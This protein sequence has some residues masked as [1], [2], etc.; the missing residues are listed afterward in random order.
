MLTSEDG[1]GVVVTGVTES[2]SAAR[3]KTECLGLL[4]S[5]VKGDG[6]GP[7][8]AVSKAHVLADAV[9]SDNSR[10]CVSPLHCALR[11]QSACPPLVVGLAKETL[12]GREASVHDELEIA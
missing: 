2:D 12:E 11:S 8:T 1:E 10:S 7:Q 4:R 3:V 6:H 5:N 9:V